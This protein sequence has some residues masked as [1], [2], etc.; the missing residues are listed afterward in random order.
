MISATFFDYLFD[1]AA[2]CSRRGALKEP[3]QE[4][5]S[6]LR[7][8]SPD[9]GRLNQ[10]MVLLTRADHHEHESS[11]PHRPSPPLC[12]DPVRKVSPPRPRI[13]VDPEPR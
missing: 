11:R 10:R 4:S 3:V 2:H 7:T 13:P 6:G 5:N 1:F 12:L 9:C 8:P